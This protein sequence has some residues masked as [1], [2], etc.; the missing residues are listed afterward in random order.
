MGASDVMDYEWLAP[1][2]KPML[3]GIG[4][5]RKYPQIL[6]QQGR[7]YQHGVEKRRGSGQAWICL[8]IPFFAEKKFWK[9]G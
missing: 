9:T 2:V 1:W 6:Y 5:Q 8:F 4:G 7:R 3:S